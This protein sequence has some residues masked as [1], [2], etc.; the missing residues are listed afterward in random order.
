ITVSRELNLEDML[1]RYGVRVNPNLVLDLQCAPIPIVTSYVGN[2]PQQRLIPWY[3]FPLIFPSSEHPIVRNLNAIRCEFV[4]SIDTVEAADV[5]KTILLSTSRYSRVAFTPARISLSILEQEP[6]KKQFNKGEQVIAVLLEGKFSSLYKNRIP[7]NIASAPE[8][9]FKEKSVETK[10]LVISDGDMIENRIRKSN[11][12]VIPL[13]YDKYTD[14]VYGN[15]SFLLNAIDYML[16]E[17]GLIAARTKQVKLRLLDK[18]KLAEYKEKVGYI[19]TA[20][21]LLLVMLLGFGKFYWRKRK[22]S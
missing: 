7:E 12:A 13:G 5:K 6:D 4:S 3:Y 15:K 21:P 8:I 20:V 18:T 2:Q 9:K 19:N 17:N 1:F 16:D 10:M 14:Q 22:Y 11:G